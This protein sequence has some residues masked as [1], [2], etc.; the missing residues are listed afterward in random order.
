MANVRKSPTSTIASVDH[1]L[2][3]MVDRLR[4]RKLDLQQYH[5]QAQDLTKQLAHLFEHEEKLPTATKRQQEIITA[6]DITKNQA[7]AAAVEG[8]D[9]ES[10]VNRESPE[11]VKRRSAITISI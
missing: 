3:G 4:E 5:K 9:A 6:L 7:P 10:E 11:S 2:E 1:A 8:P